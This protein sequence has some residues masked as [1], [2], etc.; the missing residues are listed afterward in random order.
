M[1]HRVRTDIAD[2][3]PRG[4]CRDNLWVRGSCMKIYGVDCQ[5]WRPEEVGESLIAPISTDALQTT[6]SPRRRL[7]I[8]SVSPMTSRGALDFDHYKPP[9]VVNCELG[10]L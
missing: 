2:W 4:R 7:L 1:T 10:Q 5:F 9:V 6:S 8:D 3:N